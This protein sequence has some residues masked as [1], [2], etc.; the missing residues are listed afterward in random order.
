MSFVPVVVQVG[1]NREIID[2][3]Q[4]GS[5][6]LSTEYSPTLQVEGDSVS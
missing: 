2:V 5:T 1:Q 4:S 3:V 6:E